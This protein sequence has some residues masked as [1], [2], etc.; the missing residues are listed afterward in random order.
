MTETTINHKLTAVLYADVVG[1]SRLTRQDEMGSHQQVMAVLDY[2]SDTIKKNDGV[3]LRYA[4]D[5]ILAEFQSMVAAT[6]AAVSIQNELFARNLDEADHEKVQIRIGLNLGEVMQD[7][8][9]IFGDGVNLAARLEAAASPGGVCISSMVHDQIDGKV[10]VDFQDCGEESFKNFD[11]PVR[12]YRWHPDGTSEMGVASPIAVIG[13]RPAIAVL[14]FDNLS[15]DPEQDY[16]VDGI[17]EDI[18]T[19]LS[20][21]KDLFVIARNSSSVYK[22][23]TPDIT[24]VAKDL[25]VQYVLEG[26]IRRAGN[27]IRLNAQLIDGKTN[28]HIWAERY[29]RSLEDIFEVQDDLTNTIMNTLI[30]KI[31]TSSLERALRRPP[32]NMVAYDHYLRGMA[33]IMRLN[34]GDNLLAQQ[35]AKKAVELDPTYAR[36]HMA[37]AWAR[38]YDYLTGWS[39]DRNLALREGRASALK[40]ID[41]DNTDFWGYTAL[42]MAEL[43]SNNHDRALNV[44]DDAIRLCPNSADARAIRAIVLNFVGDPEQGLQE[45]FLAIRHN[46]NHPYWYEIGPGRALFMLKRYQEAIPYLERLVNAGENIATWRTLL[47][48]TYMALGREAEANTE[49]TRAVELMPNLSITEVLALIPMRDNEVTERYAKLLS[50]AGLPD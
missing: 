6:M 22:G 21:E 38:I 50:E 15:N 42:A 31:A 32:K 46:P 44:I 20:R 4:G 10:D 47:A 36:G 41:C 13:D 19:E 3:V 30:Q 39:E 9:E 14:P 27:R 34:K 8:G 2:A 28:H 33:L 23:Q 35:E 43:F 48:A 1:Y 17:T 45:A 37:F 7:R 25:G 12:V 11:R 26:S 16:F 24:Q 49:V 18:I 29:D 5:A 40:A